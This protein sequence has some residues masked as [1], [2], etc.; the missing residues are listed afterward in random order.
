MDQETAI[1]ARLN[2]ATQA[3]FRG[4]VPDEVLTEDIVNYLNERPEEPDL[5]SS[6]ESEEDEPQSEESDTEPDLDERDFAC[7]DS[8]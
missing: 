2:A 4:M 8:Y 3:N 7:V 1:A 5:E 6:S